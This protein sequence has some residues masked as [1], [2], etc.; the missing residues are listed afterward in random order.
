METH[1]DDVTLVLDGPLEADVRDMAEAEVGR[2]V[3]KAPAPVLF[4][5]MKVRAEPQRP[6]PEHVIAQGTLDINGNL[7]RAEAA[8]ESA[9]QSLDR[10]GEKL[11][12]RLSKVAE[13]RETRT[14]RPP[15]TPPGQ[16][17]SGDLPD[18]RPSFFPRPPEDREIIRRKTFAP[19]PT[20]IEEAVFDLEVLDHRFLLFTDETDGTLAVVAERDDEVYL[21]RIDGSEP[22]TDR[23]LPVEVE[24]SPAAEVDED[25]AIEMLDVSDAPFLFFRDTD[26]GEGSVLYRRYDGH[27]GLVR[28][29]DDS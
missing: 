16:W 13:K 22:A 1:F 19:G 5:R 17:R 10:L 6:D 26:T 29:R 2:L 27:Y 21:Q 25:K 20:S 12:R 18:H 4:A 11:D 14:E 28:P 8:G 9:R 7:I 24:T 23:P 3:D 15:S